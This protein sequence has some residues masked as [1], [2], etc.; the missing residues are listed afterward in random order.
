MATKKAGSKS[1]GGKKASAK[2]AA[3]NPYSPIQP[4]YGRPILDAIKRGNIA[5]MKKLA[6]QARAHVKDVNAALAKL[7]ASLKK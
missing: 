3:K 2:A 7:D 5:E 1:G 6:T 4:L